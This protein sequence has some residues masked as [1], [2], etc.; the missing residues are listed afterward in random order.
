MKNEISGTVEKLDWCTFLALFDESVHGA[1]TAARLAQGTSALVAFENMA[2]DSSR[3]GER[4][5]MRVGPGCSYTLEEAVKSH[6]GQTPSVF[7]YPRAYTD[8]VPGKVGA[9]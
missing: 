5:A 1:V 6:L 7:Q 2:L 3:M 8:E 9:S 4:T